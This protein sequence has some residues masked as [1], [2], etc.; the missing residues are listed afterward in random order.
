MDGM[1][2]VGIV[3][4][5]LAGVRAAAELR[6]AGF[7]GKLT[8]W[9]AE[10]REPYDR[11]P[12]TKSL[13]GE[14]VRPLASQGLGDLA[15]LG[16]RVVPEA[17]ASVELSPSGALRVSGVAVDAAILATGAAP[18]R[19]MPGAHVVYTSDD[20]ARLAAAIPHSAS[21]RIAGAGWIGTEIASAVASAGLP[22]PRVEL[23]E[24][25][26][27]ILG[28]SFHGAVDDLWLGW[29]EDGG[30]DVRLGQPLPEGQ[31][32]DAILVQAT[33]SAPA[34]AFL[35]VE[36]NRTARGALATDSLTRVLSGGSPVPGLYAV[37]DC[38][39]ALLGET[40][41]EGGH[42]TKALNDGKA[43]AAAIL[44][45]PPPAYIPPVEVFSTQFGHE[46]G[47]V[48]T[49]P[50]DVAPAR[51]E[52]P[53]G[54]SVMRWER[55]GRLLALLSVDAPRELSRARKALRVRRD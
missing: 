9:D 27:H 25:S 43:T 49:V 13:F 24:S 23:W 31:D 1:E 41:L 18:H 14:R 47:L 55:E 19:K 45:V 51:E 26:G 42:W 30:V 37:G 54:G 34:L 16:V 15:G 3:G 22:G 33:G 21:V 38:A 8:A 7:T 10:D 28:R 29:L 40:T 4:T 44:G 53:R 12:L 48:G 35:A 50:A 36:A 2:H 5:G 39:D 46:I 32:A 17:A 52:P 6:A 20:A 11:P